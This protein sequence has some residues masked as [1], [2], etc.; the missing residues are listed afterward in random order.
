[1]LG[2]A[3]APDKGTGPVVGHHLGSLINQLFPDSRNVIGDI[4]CPVGNLFLDVIH[5]PNTLVDELLVL[6]TVLEDMPHH[7]PDNCHICTGT[8]LEVEVSM[9][10]RAGETRIYHDERCVVPL[11]GAHQVNEGNRVSLSRVTANH[12]HRLAVVYIVVRV[13]HCTVAPG[14]SHTGYRGGMTDSRLVVT[15]VRTPEGVELTEEVRLLV[16]EFGRPQPV[17]RIGAGLLSDLKHL[18]AD[19]VDRIVPAHSYPFAANQF[20][21]I[22]EATLTMPMF[23]HRCT[24]SAVGAQVKGM[25]KSRFL[26]HPDSVVDLGIDAATH[27]AVCAHRSHRLGSLS[28]GGDRGGVSLS[29]HGRCQSGCSRSASEGD[30]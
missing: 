8:N 30:S 13:G 21:G 7:A 23:P 14:V 28:T 26:T 29:H 11:L 5:P 19:L 2:T 16:V 17:N 9:R 4:R 27:R 25:I 10:S 1:M 20:G 18:V 12:Q 15:V 22:F 3:H 6:P 24:F